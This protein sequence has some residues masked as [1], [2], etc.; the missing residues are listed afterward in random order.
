MHH[1][2][3]PALL[4]QARPP[5]ARLTCRLVTDVA[6]LEGLR[7]AWLDLLQRS[8]ANEPMLSPEWLLTWW[9]VFG[10]Q[11]GR[12]LRV[13][14]LHQG[15]RLVGLA[16]LLGRRHWY[17]SV[18]PFRR[19]EFLASGERE[20]D[21]ICSDYL[22]VLVERGLERAVAQELASALKAGVAGTWDELVLPVMDGENLL[23]GLLVEAFQ[24]EGLPAA[25]EVT[26][27][28]PYVPLPASW[29]EYLGLLKGSHRGFVTKAL[30]EF[31][32]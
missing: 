17:R 31:Q 8:S 13:V 22:N 30:R 15:E 3:P 28:A 18:L 21:A 24:G 7:P 16:P 25:S 19:L 2:A 11:Q 32:K 6:E 9:R 5:A 12:R 23:P 26:G 27:Q 4:Q 10:P 20:E 14:Q 1:A 29:D